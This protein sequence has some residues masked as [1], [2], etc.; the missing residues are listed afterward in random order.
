MNLRIKASYNNAETQ[1][2]RDNRQVA[3]RAATE[4]IVL[5]ENDGALPVAPGKI[6]LYGA[7]ADR[8]IKGG[9]GSGE[10]NERH[11]V[12]VCEGLKA[13]GFTVTTEK[14]IA[15]YHADFLAAKAAFK[16][17][18]K[19]NIRKGGASAMINLMA[20]QFHYPF[21]RAVTDADIKDSDTD[22][23]VYVVARQAG[24]CA[25]RSMAA[26]DYTLSD[27]E[28]QNLKTVAAVYA[29]T[30]LVINVG[31]AIDLGC[32]DDIAG[33][34]AVLFLCQQGM[35][36]GTALADLLAGKVSPCAC[37]TD[38]WAK[39]YEDIPFANEYSY[40]KGESVQEDYREGLY[41]GYR[42]YDSF[43]IAPRYPFGYGLTYSSFEI[44]C[45][46]V[47]LDKTTVTVTASVKNTG[48]QYSG[49]KVVQLY[50][51]CPD[52]ALKKEHQSLAAYAK[53][54]TLAPGKQQDVTLTFDL[55]RFA[56]YDEGAKQFILEQGEYRCHIGES[57]R[58]TALCAVFTLDKTVVTERCC[59]I[60]P[61]TRTF[62]ELVCDKPRAAE[63]LDGVPQLRVNADDIQTV[64]HNYE[65]EQ[66]IPAEVEAMMAKLT[67]EERFALLFGTGMFGAKP[68]LNV[69]GSA[70]FTLA[71]PEKGLCSVSLA[72]GP[73]GLRLTRT[74]GINKRGGIKTV[75]G[76]M[77]IIDFLPGIIKKF[78]M[79]NPKKDTLIYQYATAFPV[80]TALAQSWNIALVEEVGR[81]VGAE[82]VEYGVTLWLAPGMNIHRNPLCGRNFEYYS[83]DPLLTGT[84]AAAMTRGV[85]SHAG[86]FVTIKHYA[87]NNQEKDRNHVSSNMSERTLREIYLKG[88]RIAVEDGNPGALMTSYNPLNGVYTPNSHDLC[89]KA[90]RREWG[91]DGV[92][93]TDWFSTGKGLGSNGA[94]IAAGNDLIMPGGGAYQKAA[95]KEL[96]A[97]VFT[98]ADIDRC[99]AN[100]LKIVLQ[101]GPQKEYFPA[102]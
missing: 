39:R 20:E 96:A 37:L 44:K 78:M 97:G 32:L 95:K 23:C 69:P 84:V 87:A 40:L 5:L 15:D 57:S 52:G 75:D 58:E 4:G 74:S 25:D 70:A 59:N 81:A 92:V 64:T 21:G 3:Y 61:Q 27:V 14:W 26:H 85:Q 54:D 62:D 22:T 98:Q 68:Y 42:Y 43:G 102:K 36:G 38:S 7:G 45:K 55:T 89:T 76:I 41:V 13:A 35:E 11:S 72:D 6:A 91:F 71:L 46:D 34:N 12:T 60:C 77:D 53:T 33:I 18:M 65:K 101:S 28:L 2:E 17:T 90:L 56:S 79:G 80:G 29:K 1:R 51:R 100:V 49:K 82:M 16:E 47:K 19:K 73:A 31:S 50:L 94:A 48:K 63:K 99:C 88:F 30:I 93:M 67:A 66:A 8:T 83:E 86:C 10:V 24:E 9:T